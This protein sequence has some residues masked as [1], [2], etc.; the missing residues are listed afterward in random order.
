VSGS[1]TGTAHPGLCT[2]SAAFHNVIHSEKRDTDLHVGF[3]IQ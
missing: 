3:H 1:G 2:A